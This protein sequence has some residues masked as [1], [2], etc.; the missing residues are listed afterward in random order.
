MCLFHCGEWTS[1][2]E[3]TVMAKVHGYFQPDTVRNICWVQHDMLIGMRVSHPKASAN[4]TLELDYPPASF[5]SVKWDHF[6]FPV[7]LNF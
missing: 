7:S 1:V 4:E 6:D 5:N 2:L 3:Y